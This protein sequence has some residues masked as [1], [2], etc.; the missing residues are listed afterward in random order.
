MRQFQASA[1]ERRIWIDAELTSHPMECGWASEALFFLI[2]EEIEGDNA[3]L[4]ARVQLSPDGIN[5][6]DEGTTFETIAEPGTFF[7]RVSHFGTWLRVVGAVSGEGAR[8]KVSV[9]LHLKE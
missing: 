5:W 7:V 9:H 2:V 4:N 1:V 3:Q 6:I 8:V